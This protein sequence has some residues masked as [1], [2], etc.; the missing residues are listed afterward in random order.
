MQTLIKSDEINISELIEIQEASQKLIKQEIKDEPNLVGINDLSEEIPPWKSLRQWL[1]DYRT[2]LDLQKIANRIGTDINTLES[3][4]IMEPSRLSEG[5][6]YL[7]PIQLSKLSSILHFYGFKP[8]KG[9]LKEYSID[10][11]STI[12]CIYFNIPPGVFQSQTR[13][14]EVVQAR[15]IAMWLSKKH[16]KNS[17]SVIGSEIGDKDHATVVYACKTV[18]SLIETEKRFKVQ[19]GEIEK[20]LK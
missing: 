7:N 3:F 20:K 16:T 5:F 6:C 8:E 19:V 14:R 17:L 4:I 2:F 11:I 10:H 13:K 15:Q 18:E 9:I 1:V 12:V